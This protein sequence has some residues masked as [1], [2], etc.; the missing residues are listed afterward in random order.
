MGKVR[1][2]QIACYI[3]D[4]HYERGVKAFE[5][6]TSK[7]LWAA[8]ING[9]VICHNAFM[10][11]GSSRGS[12]YKCIEIEINGENHIIREHTHDSM[13]WDN[14]EEPTSRDKRNLFLAVLENKIEEIQELCYSG[15]N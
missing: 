11:R 3:Y 4:K 10:E 15:V 8:G 12:Y 6:K 7:I 2:L 9:I 14:W 5:I 1:T 13:F